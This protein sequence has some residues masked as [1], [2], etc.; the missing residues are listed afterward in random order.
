[1]VNTLFAIFLIFS[2]ALV[3]PF[4]FYSYRI[5]LNRKF[6]LFNLI[7]VNSEELKDA[8][9][10]FKHYENKS[11]EQKKKNYKEDF[12]KELSEDLYFSLFS[13][14]FPLVLLFFVT[15]IGSAAI[16]IKLNLPIA[17]FSEFVTKM[18]GI[19]IEV[20]LAFIG[21][22]LWGLN[23]ILI[24]KRNVDLTP[25]SLHFIWLR[26][27]I[28]SVIGF[29]ILEFGFD[30][31]ISYSISFILGAFPVKTLK[32]F[33]QGIPGKYLSKFSNKKLESEDVSH[34]FKCIEGLH[35]LHIK[36]LQEEDIHC[37]QNLAFQDPLRL[38]LRTN[39]E[40]KVLLDLVDQ[41]FLFCYVE[42][43]ITNLRKFGIRGA[44]EFASLYM[45]Y[46]DVEN[47]SDEEC[48]HIRCV[49]SEVSKILEIK[50]DCTIQVMHQLYD[51]LHLKYIWMLWG[52][53]SGYDEAK[54]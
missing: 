29:I 10:H 41:A 54:L 31:K 23:E 7:F 9:P 1:M 46:L 52:V 4:L 43:K 38:Y 42:E 13:Y 47:G 19:E 39:I 32:A 26:I 16:Y 50:E 21:G 53:T 49:I 15:F 27:I 44:I 20:L 40:W 12:F 8:L 36:R 34:R 14:V 24:R 37:N 51:D 11:K 2:P 48:K 33:F 45:E 30:P 3:F 25:F 5:S 6:A 18:Q 22:Y 28:V 35:P 17:I